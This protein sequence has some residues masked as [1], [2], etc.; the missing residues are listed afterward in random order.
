M[1]AWEY[2]GELILALL[3]SV[4]LF[5][6][7]PR[8]VLHEHLCSLR[9]DLMLILGIAL[10]IGATVWVGFFALLGGEFGAWLRKKNEASH[11]SLALAAPIFSYLLGFLLLLFTACLESSWLTRM[12]VLV[13]TYDLINF[14]TMI[15]NVNGVVRLWQTWEQQGRPL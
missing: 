8:A 5:S 7:A 15:R 4:L 2:A 14:I 12:N 13:L 11:Y 1:S 3:V 9:T 6:F 10:G